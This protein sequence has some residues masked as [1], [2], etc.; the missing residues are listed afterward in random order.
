MVKPCIF[1]FIVDNQTITECTT[2]YNEP[3]D[4]PWPWCSTKVDSGGNHNLRVG[5]WG[6]C[7]QGCNQTQL[8]INK[9]KVPLKNGKTWTVIGFVKLS[10]I[11]YQVINWLIYN[12]ILCAFW[13]QSAVLET[14]FFCLLYHESVGINNE[15]MDVWSAWV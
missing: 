13:L 1:P 14:T 3:K 9:T 5:F 12:F 2:L 4:E 15:H 11:F 8:E 7:D 6:E 10:L